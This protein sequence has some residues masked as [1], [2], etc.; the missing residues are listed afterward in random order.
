LDEWTNKIFIAP[1][2]FDPF[3][4]QNK[5]TGIDTV[6]YVDLVATVT[7]TVD[8][9][10]FILDG[11]VN[12]ANSSYANALVAAG[13][14]KVT[15]QSDGTPV[16]PSVSLV[17][18]TTGGAPYYTLTF[19]AA[20]PVYVQLASLSTLAGTPYFVKYLETLTPL[21]VTIVA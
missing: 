20:Y 15:K 19:A 13:A 11:G 9:R 2:G 16:T 7:K 14:W 18:P 21:A 12:L 3:V 5:L 1:M 4:G 17:V 10:P 6:S 8:V